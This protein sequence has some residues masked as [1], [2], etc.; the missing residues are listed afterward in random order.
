[1]TNPLVNRRLFLFRMGASGL[2]LTAPAL[3]DTQPLLQVVKDPNCG[4]CSAWIEIMAD[5]GFE[6]YV[7]VAPYDSLKRLKAQSG[8]SEDMASCHTARVNGYIIEGHV[9]PT[10][11]QRLLNE[12]PDAIGLSVPG[13]PWGSPGMGPAREREAYSVFL[14]RIDGTTE[15]FTHYKAA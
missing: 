2:A 10:D 12:R 1:M 5:A 9:P 11:V 6:T 8:V 13:M 3:A 7:Q 4:C 14:I 15:I